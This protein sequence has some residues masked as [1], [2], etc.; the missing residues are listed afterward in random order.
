MINYYPKKKY[1]LQKNYKIIKNIKY[2][3]NYDHIILFHI[4]TENINPEIL[5]SIQRLIDKVS[6]YLIIIT[7]IKSINI[8]ILLNSYNKF[9]LLISNNLIFVQTI[10]KGMDIG[11]FYIGLNLIKLYDIDYKFITK[12]H[13][14]TNKIWCNN[15]LEIYNQEYLEKEFNKFQYNQDLSYQSYKCSTVLDNLNR[16]IITFVSSINNINI[17]FLYK[18]RDEILHLNNN[19]IDLDFFKKRV[20]DIDIK[21]NKIS[22]DVIM[23]NF[24]YF[25]NNNKNTLDIFNP[26]VYHKLKENIPFFNAGSIATYKKCVIDKLIDFIPLSIYENFPINYSSNTNLNESTIL[27][28]IER[29]LGIIEFIIKKY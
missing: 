10:N 1:I 17:K 12:I 24:N 15:L 13:T 25:K 16:D 9:F 26:I 19:F 6:N 18:L 21:K 11:G 5:L 3:N 20:Y 22:D 28:S 14:K 7:A 8:K 27:H 2:N 29:F 4:G 23:N